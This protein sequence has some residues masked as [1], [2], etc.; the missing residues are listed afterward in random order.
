MLF[1]LSKYGVTDKL[2]DWIREVLI[3]RSFN[4]CIN[5][6]ISKLFNVCSSVP[7]S[8]K[9]G[10]F[11]YVL[12]TND[13]TQIFNFARFNM[14]ADDLTIYAS[15]N[16]D[17]DRIELQNKLDLFCEW[18]SKWGLTINIKKCKLMHFGHSDNY[19]QYKLNDANLEIS[20]CERILGAHTD[21][22]LTFAN[23]VYICIKKASNVCNCILLNVYNAD[24][25]ILIQLYKTYARLFLEYASVIYSPHFRYFID[26]IEN[27]QRHFT[28]R[29]RGFKDMS[30]IL[31]D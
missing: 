31:T 4:V 11:M 10:P 2:L 3:G 1:K 14:Y 28:T 21:N 12:F 26:T 30:Y 17:K 25:S 5:S 6:C 24:N 20:D 19:F 7:Q 22:K 29:L 13:I 9:L 23:H 15:I 18:C 27:V 8:S 16:N